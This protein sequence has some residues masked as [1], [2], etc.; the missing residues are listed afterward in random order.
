MLFLQLSAP[1]EDAQL[2]FHLFILRAR[3]H[4]PKRL[5][6]ERQAVILSSL[7]HLKEGV[8]LQFY[9][10]HNLLEKGNL[11]RPVEGAGAY[12]VLMERGGLNRLAMVWQASRAKRAI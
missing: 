9:F 1:D 12:S 4:V 2:H 7:Q 10:L 11:S 5:Q 6:A 3:T 8:I